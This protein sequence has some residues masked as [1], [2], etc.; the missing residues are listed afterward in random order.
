M[1]SWSGR[2]AGHYWTVLPFVQDSLLDSTRKRVSAS[3]SPWSLTVA[4]PVLGSVRLSGRLFLPPGARRLLLAIHGLGGNAESTYLRQSL[5]AAHAAGVACLCLNLRGADGQGE[6]FYHA[7]LTSD[8]HAALAC[9]ELAPFEELHVLGFSLGG[10]LALRLAC[11]PHD[12]RLR[13]VAAICAPLDLEHTQRELDSARRAFYR[14]YMLS[15]LKACYL[16]VAQRHAVPTPPARVLRI[17]RLREWDELTVVPRFGF[18]SAAQ[19]YRQASAS[20]HLHQLSVRTLLVQAEHDPMVLAQ[21]VR[22]T[23]LTTPSLL[24]VRWIRRAGHVGFPPDLNLDEPAPA[25]LASQVLS[26]LTAARP[27]G[28]AGR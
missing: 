25:G 12:A 15:R 1:N 28:G 21:T 16:S 6:D 18:G 17:R 5:Q 7:A 20:T 13:S 9:A 14:H 24:D 4:D 10:H 22:P 2:L 19:Y 27:P 3:S 11:E 23:L 8:L 26:W